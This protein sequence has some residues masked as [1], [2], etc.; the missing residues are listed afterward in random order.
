MDLIRGEMK[1]SETF[2]LMVISLEAALRLNLFFSSTSA[3]LIR[4]D[5]GIT[6]III[7]NFIITTLLIAILIST[8]LQH[9]HNQ[10]PHHQTHHHHHH[11]T[12]IT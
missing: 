4:I 11:I 2:L 9:L 1:R 10:H 3:D 12:M 5:I 6:F 8:Q 7:I